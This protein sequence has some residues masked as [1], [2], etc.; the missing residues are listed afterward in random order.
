MN[1]RKIRVGGCP[2]TASGTRPSPTLPLQLQPRYRSAVLDMRD[3]G[4][5]FGPFLIDFAIVAIATV[6]ITSVLGLSGSETFRRLLPH[7]RLVVQRLDGKLGLAGDGRQDGAERPSHN[8][9]FR[10]AHHLWT[11]HWKTLLEVRVGNHLLGRLHDGGVD[12]QEAGAARH[13]GADTGRQELGPPPSRRPAADSDLVFLFRRL[14]V[15]LPPGRD[16]EIGRRDGL[17][18]RWAKHPWG[19]ESPSRY[20]PADRNGR[21]RFW[22]ASASPRCR[23]GG[24]RTSRFGW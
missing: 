14:A 12:F 16:G 9:P 17:K 5:G 20:W 3:S 6:I 21:P 15:I 13:D 24:C 1:A 23:T 11:R 10:I 19:F 2:L 8:Q 18:I 4:S 22:I 7:C